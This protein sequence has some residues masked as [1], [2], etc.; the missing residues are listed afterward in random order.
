MNCEASSTLPASHLFSSFLNDKEGVR[1]IRDGEG[2]SVLEGVA[3]IV[4]VADPVLVDVFHGEG[5]GQ[6]GVLPSA[7][8][9]DH[10]VAWRLHHSECDSVSLPRT[11]EQ[12]EKRFVIETR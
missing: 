9:L 7:G 2:E 5:G 3:A 1:S 12:K 11:E 8:P 6:A 4:A 10:A